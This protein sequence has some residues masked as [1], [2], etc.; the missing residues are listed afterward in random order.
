MDVIGAIPRL[1]EVDDPAPGEGEVLI[2]MT[3]AAIN[4]VDL[5]IAAG[6]FHGGHPPLPYAPGL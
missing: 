5:A 3:A 2:N 1:V 6:L 4:P